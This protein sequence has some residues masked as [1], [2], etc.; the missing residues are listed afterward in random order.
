MSQPALWRRQRERGKL[1]VVLALPFLIDGDMSAS[2]EDDTIRPADFPMSPAGCE[3]VVDALG[4]DPLRLR[5]L[6]TLQSLCG[7]VVATLGLNVVGQPA[8]H[9]FPGHAGVTGLYLLSESHLACH[10]Y[11]EFALATF[12]LYCCRRLPH[13]PWEDR[14]KDRL[15]AGR[16]EVRELARGRGL[17]EGGG[18]LGSSVDSNRE[19]R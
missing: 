18:T 1:G 3:W 7:E 2:T 9:R 11:P 8:W 12:N 5:S 14:L 6:A 19:G 16:V 15:A 17:Y 10:T 4:C 13:W